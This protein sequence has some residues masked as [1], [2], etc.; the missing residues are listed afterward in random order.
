M[1]ADL[2]KLTCDNAVTFQ[3]QR[4]EWALLTLQSLLQLILIPYWTQ[5]AKAS[6]RLWVLGRKESRHYLYELDSSSSQ[7]FVSSPIEI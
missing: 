4:T 3:S 1:A 6:I 7:E 2:S 5:R